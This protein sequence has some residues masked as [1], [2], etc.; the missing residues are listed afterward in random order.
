[1]LFA[2]LVKADIDNAPENLQTELINLRYDTDFNG[3]FSETDLQYF[4]SCLPVSCAQILWV[5]NDCGVRQ[6]LASEQFFAPY[7]QQ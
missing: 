6:P 3:E 5:T 4:Y 1:M 2:L 7:Q